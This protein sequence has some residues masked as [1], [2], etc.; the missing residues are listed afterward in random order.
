LP[1]AL[2][3]YDWLA[4]RVDTLPLADAANAMGRHLDTLARTGATDRAFSLAEDLAQRHAEDLVILR[5][6]SGFFSEYATPER[7]FQFSSDLLGR[8]GDAVEP[9][10]RAALLRQVGESAFQAGNLEAA[11]KPLQEAAAIGP[12][13]GDALRVLAQVYRAQHDWCAATGALQRHLESTS[14]EDRVALL[15]EI[16]DLAAEQMHDPTSAAQYYLNALADKPADRTVLLK[17]AQLYGAEQDWTKLLEVIDNLAEITEDPPQKAKYLETAARVAEREL[18]DAQAAWARVKRALELDPHEESLVH[19][20]VRLLRQVGDTE[21]VQTLLQDQIRAAS[22]AR[23]VDRAAHFAEL[24]ADLHLEELRADDAVQVYEAVQA[25]NP[26]SRAIQAALIELY[27][28][29]PGRYLG[30]AVAAQER[31]L[32]QDPYGADAYRMLRQIYAGARRPD[33]AWCASQV[34]TVLN[35]AN[36]REEVFFKTHRRRDGLV[37]DAQ[38][39]DDDWARLVVHPQLSPLLTGILALLEPCMVDVRATK[40]EDTGYAQQT[41]LDPAKHSSPMVHAL[42]HAAP[43]LRVSLPRLFHNPDSD[44]GVVMPNTSP[45]CMVLGPAAISSEVSPRQA[46]FVAATHL[47]SLKRGLF[48]RY[49]VPTPAALKAWVLA[50]VKLVAPRIPVAAELEGPVMDAHQALS[51]HQR[52]QLLDRLA[53][54]IHRLLKEDTRLDMSRWLAAVDFTVDRV[55]LIASDDLTTALGVLGASRR[56]DAEFAAADRARELLRYAASGQY[57]ELRDRLRLGL[58]WRHSDVEE[59]ALDELLGV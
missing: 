50:A 14:G 13:S 34:L 35:A 54:P 30:R 45:R 48:V 10:V 53:Q 11:A 42:R 57:L 44:R 52:G 2:R 19:R 12:E 21:G 37:S 43:L 41:A 25:L 17:L 18:G 6:I 39:T 7:A 23:D 16:G 40:L 9:P 22:E 33:G 8:F 59:V 26:G 55:G 47:T 5:R 20:A 3:H 56:A 58:N 46:A 28:T 32:R 49:L 38:I 36:P 31:I 4:R 27:A 51:Q 15:I 24:L 1:E 29:D